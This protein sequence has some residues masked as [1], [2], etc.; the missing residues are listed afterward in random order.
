MKN[1]R[2]IERE[3]VEWAEGAGLTPINCSGDFW[4]I[5]ADSPIRNECTKADQCGLAVTSNGSLKC[6]ECVIVER[7][8]KIVTFESVSLTALAKRLIGA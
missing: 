8:N 3:L 1:F 7:K 4:I 6:S 2:E 5:A